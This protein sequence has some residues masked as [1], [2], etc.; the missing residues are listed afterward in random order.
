MGLKIYWKRSDDK[1]DSK[2]NQ[3]GPLSVPHYFINDRKIITS[4]FLF[5]N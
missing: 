5:V 4:C 2:K 3:F 1:Q